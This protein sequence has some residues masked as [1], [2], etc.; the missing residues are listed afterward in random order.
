VTALPQ[1]PGTPPAGRH[2]G[3][4][5][6]VSLGSGGTN[7]LDG[8]LLATDFPRLG[9]TAAGDNPSRAGT[10]PRERASAPS[11]SPD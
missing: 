1:Q 5:P 9:G 8:G 4:V 7:P 6:A 3:F 10:P 2:P 11:T